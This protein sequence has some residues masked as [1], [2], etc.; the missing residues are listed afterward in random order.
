MQISY[1]DQAGLAP[2][3]SRTAEVNKL[4][5]SIKRIVSIFILSK[6]SYLNAT[7]WYFV[8]R[9]KGV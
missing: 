7:L 6:N 8:G 4:G 1:K 5:Y 9:Y 2:Q 3:G